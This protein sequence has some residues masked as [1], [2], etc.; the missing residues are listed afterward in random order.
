MASLQGLQCPLIL[1]SFFFFFPFSNSTDTLTPIQPIKDGQTLISAREV[2]ELGFFSP[3]N[4]K[5][6]YVGIWYKNVPG[7]TI[8]WVANR[9]NPISNS[10]GILTIIGGNLALIDGPD[11]TPLWS[12]NIST[13]TNDSSATL[14]DSGN[15]VLKDSNENVLWESFDYPTDSYLPGMKFGWDRRTGLNRHLTSWKTASDP[16]RGKFSYGLDLR[17]KPQYKL[18]KGSDLIYRSG[19]WNGQRL[20][21][22][23]ISLMFSFQY[24]E[25]KDEIYVT[26]TLFDSSIPSRL[27]LDA[28]GIIQRLTWNE[29]ILRWNLAYSVPTG[30]CDDYMRCGPYSICDE[31][32]L[33]NSEC[34][35]LRG[36]EPRSAKDWKVGNWSAGC[37]RRRPLDCGKGDGFFKLARVKI[38]DTSRARSDPTLSLKE[39]GAECSKNCACTAYASV[40]ISGDRSGCVM[41]DGA[42]IDLKVFADGGKDLYTRVDASELDATSYKQSRGKKK[43]VVIVSTIIVAMVAFISCG[44]CCWRRKIGL[45]MKN[46]SGMVFNRDDFEGGKGSEILLL[47]ADGIASSTNN[48]SESNMLGMGG[49]GPVYKGKLLSG[50]EIAV[51]RLSKSSGQ[52]VEE[53]KNE[54]SLIAKL[55]HKNLVRLLGCCI[56]GEE[57]MLIYEYMRNKS[58]DCFIFGM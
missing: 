34:T 44:Y 17:G 40:D 18:M 12:T 52:G 36:F 29:R 5:N 30:P 45:K 6:R 46:S 32:R 15:L 38:P 13:V 7:Q 4:S 35:C 28:S 2:F 56:D 24:V 8:V 16:A 49:F 48:Y 3:L 55:Q 11:R 41:W 20:G 27:V 26:Y 37:V 42:L 23:N 51:K 21:G 39:C 47:D 53:F 10:S 9:E 31:T 43:V 33:P 58:L 19:P 50:Q 22:L 14:L 54:I 1:F 57:K 25:N